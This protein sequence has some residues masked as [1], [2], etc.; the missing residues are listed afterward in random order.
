MLN[1]IPLNKNNEHNKGDGRLTEE[2]RNKISETPEFFKKSMS[3]V[4]RNVA[5]ARLFL[6]LISN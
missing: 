4:L 6:T 5:C 2:Q 1:T 3:L